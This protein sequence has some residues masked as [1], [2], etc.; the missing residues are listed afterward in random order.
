MSKARKATIHSPVFIEDSNLSRAWSRLLLQFLKNSGTKIAPLYI[1]IN[2]FTRDGE[3][4]EDLVLRKELDLLLKQKRLLSVRDVA[5]TIFPQRVWKM[6]SGDRFNLYKVYIDTFP[7]WKAINPRLN[8]RGLYFERLIAYGN[9][10]CD[11][12]Q[13]EW[14]LSQFNS[15]RSIR[16]S[17]LQASSFDPVRDHVPDAQLNF[18]CLQQVSF[19]PTKLGLNVNAFYATQQIFDKAY[20]N[21]LGLTH[22][23]LF[24]AHEMKMPMK[25]LN[26]M[27]GE[28]KFE[29]INKGDP[30]LIPLEK[31]ANKLVRFRNAR[32]NNEPERQSITE[33]STPEGMPSEPQ[34]EQLEGLSL[35]SNVN[36]E[37]ELNTSPKELPLNIDKPLRLPVQEPILLLRSTATKVSEVYDTFWRFTAERQSIFFR[38]ARGELPPWTRDPVLAVHRFTNTYRASDRVSQYLI[39]NVIYR[40]DLPRSPTEV[41]FRI[42]LFKLFNRIETWELL[43]NVLGHLTFEDYQFETYDAILSRAK[44]R[45]HRI[46]SAAYIMPPGGRTFGRKVKHQNHLLLLE[47][48]MAD[49]LPERLIQSRTMEEAYQNLLSYPTIG[50]FLA[51]QFITDI[52]YSDLTDFSEMEFVVPGPGARDGLRKVFI[53]S[54][55]LTESD[56]IRMVANVQEQEFTRLGLDF[57]TLWGRRLQLV[58]CQNLF[59]EVDKYARVAHPDVLGRSKRLR[60]KQKFAPLIEPIEFF[61]PPKWGLN[62]KINDV[63]RF[64]S[65]SIN[66]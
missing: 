66:L 13:L 47:R 33:S 30:E 56:L 27:V 37:N 3:V 63:D 64:D 17:K 58:D 2:D 43:E 22:L 20:G 41:I 25:S 48:M 26:V 51:Y 23:G 5:F 62:Q 11:G 24:M 34:A 44:M 52:N 65:S 16:R 7:R 57:Q 21:Y 9:G 1:S 15:T 54:G 40:D 45:G 4:V 28:A 53:D 29:R 6:S 46:Y 10:R 19:V 31:I 12:N 18:P 8:R 61:Y 59:C 32:K 39:R 49:R 42:I 50:Q 14:I 55:G 35:E 36:V 38:R 60:I